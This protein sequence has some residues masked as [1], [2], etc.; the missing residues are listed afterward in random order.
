MIT[1]EGFQEWS[2]L[3]TSK[4]GKGVKLI[5]KPTSTGEIIV[6]MARQNG[7]TKNGTQ[8]LPTF[9][10]KTALCFKFNDIEIAK[11]ARAIEKQFINYSL[12]TGEMIPELVFPH[13]NSNSPKTIKFSFTIYNTK[14]QGTLSCLLPE[15]TGNNI[16]IY[17]NEEE[18]ECIKEIFKNQYNFSQSRMLNEYV[19][20]NK[21][22][23]EI[24]TFLINKE[25][26]DNEFKSK[27]MEI[28]CKIT[29][30]LGVDNE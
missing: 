6:Q 5:L 15:G 22:K 4:D 16:G 26:D 8:T 24:M 23:E 29:N 7:T 14:L 2:T 27:V 12:G 19:D 11:I 25:K 30:K 20:N 28:L 10:Y 21:F 17:L 9:D 13:L 18:M 1:K 3:R